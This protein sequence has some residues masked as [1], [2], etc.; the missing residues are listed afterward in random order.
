MLAHSYN[1]STTEAKQ[2]DLEFE[3]RLDCKILSLRSVPSQK[4][5]EKVGVFNP[6]NELYYEIA[7]NVHNFMYHKTQI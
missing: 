3:A 2:K 1:A 6:A 7:I 5:L 4:Q